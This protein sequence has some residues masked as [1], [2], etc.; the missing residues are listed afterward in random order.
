VANLRI[1]LVVEVRTGNKHATDNGPPSPE[2]AAA[3][4]AGPP[5]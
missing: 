1:S 2:A 4:A 3:A 5:C